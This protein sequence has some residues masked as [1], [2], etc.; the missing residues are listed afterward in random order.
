VGGGSQEDS[1]CV[2][3]ARSDE[4]QPRLVAIVAQAD[5]V[6]DLALKRNGRRFMRRPFSLVT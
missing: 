4:S 2:A 1:R 5:R 3:R 6:R